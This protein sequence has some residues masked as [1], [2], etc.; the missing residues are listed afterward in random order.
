MSAKPQSTIK[1]LTTRVRQAKGNKEVFDK[2]SSLTMC[3]YCSGTNLVLQT[4]TCS[5]CHTTM[6]KNLTGT[7]KDKNAT[8]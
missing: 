5:D 1:K 6:P 3:A 7:Q 4:L 2:L 8:T